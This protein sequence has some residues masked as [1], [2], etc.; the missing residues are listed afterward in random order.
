MSAGLPDFHRAVGADHGHVQYT[1]VY[2]L[3][4][5]LLVLHYQIQWNRYAAYKTILVIVFAAKQ[6]LQ[7]V[8]KRHLSINNWRLRRDKKIKQFFLN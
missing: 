2:C 1:P 4:P 7:E 8:G 6:K 5:V 3:L